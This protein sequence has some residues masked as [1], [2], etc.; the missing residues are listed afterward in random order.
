MI[1]WKIKWQMQIKKEAELTAK[2]AESE[3]A[4]FARVYQITQLMDKR[5]TYV[6]EARENNLG[7]VEY[8]IKMENLLRGGLKKLE[9]NS[10]NK[11]LI[12]KYTKLINELF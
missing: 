4:M 1:L 3:E 7:D 6:K 11:K 8:F 12:A 10:N 9:E 5:M 2:R